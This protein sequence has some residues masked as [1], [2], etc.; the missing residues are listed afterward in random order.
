MDLSKVN[1]IGVRCGVA[2]DSEQSVADKTVVG[3]A[4]SLHGGVWV[5]GGTQL[6]AGQ[7]GTERLTG[8][9]VQQWRV[10]CVPEHSH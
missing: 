3:L 2:V 10:L 1:G 4:V 7:R 9:T 8:R 5:F 6:T